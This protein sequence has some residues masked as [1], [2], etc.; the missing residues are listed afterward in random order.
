M[1]LGEVIASG[2][3]SRFNKHSHNSRQVNKHWEKNN[4]LRGMEIFKRNQ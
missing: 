2:Y 1:R 3:Y 4:E